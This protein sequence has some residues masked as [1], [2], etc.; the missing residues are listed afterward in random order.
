MISDLLQMSLASYVTGM[1]IGDHL[2][3]SLS[4]VTILLSLTSAPPMCNATSSNDRLG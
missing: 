3:L 2:H 4:H 1:M